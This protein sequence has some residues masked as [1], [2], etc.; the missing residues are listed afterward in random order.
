MIK[1]CIERDRLIKTIIIFYIEDL[2]LY[3]CPIL[4]NNIA[5]ESGFAKNAEWLVFS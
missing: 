2:R 1:S 4:A 5:T 3:Y